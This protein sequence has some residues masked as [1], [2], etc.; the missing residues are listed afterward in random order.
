MEALKLTSYFNNTLYEYA[1][2]FVMFLAALVVLKI[3]QVIIL[4]RLK[5][6]AQKTKTDIDD[7][8]L[9]IVG[10]VKP[11]LYLLLSFYI[12]YQ[13]LNFP[14]KVDKVVGFVIFV[15]LVYEVIRSISR[16]ID[17]FVDRQTGQQKTEGEKKQTK[18]LMGM[19]KTFVMIALWIVAAI[20]ILSNYGVNVSSIIAS[21]GIGGLAVALAVQNIL[22]DIFSSFS[23]FI[24]KPFEIGDYIQIG[25]DSG[26]VEKIGLKTTRLRTLQ[27]EELVVSNKELTSA[28][29]Q[30]FKKLKNRRVVFNL[31]V[32]YGLPV[33]KL[34]AIPKIVKDVVRTKAGIKFGRCHFKTFGDYSLNFE[35]VYT[36]ESGDYKDYMD[37]NQKIN[38]DIYREF[39]KEGIDFAYPT[40]TVFVGK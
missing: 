5:K 35:V 17:Y 14:E 13:Y 21:L 31:G 36:V 15:L 27:G 30:N 20:L 18:S 23:I 12:G 4:G 38:F 8:L 22:S 10:S 6:L 1:V 28:R 34:R 25:T 7:V 37:V 16:L 9:E 39:E 29:V 32:V 2:A 24:D 33:T 11:P 40:Q 19:L 26:T 3:F